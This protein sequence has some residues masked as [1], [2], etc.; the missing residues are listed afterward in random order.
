MYVCMNVCMYVCMYVCIMYMNIDA[1][2]HA[3]GS[4]YMY[5]MIIYMCTQG[6]QLCDAAEKGDVEEMK[7]LL[8]A[9]ADKDYKDERSVR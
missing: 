7:R 6:E 9:G 8:K 4:K 1:F 5:S 2:P 3:S